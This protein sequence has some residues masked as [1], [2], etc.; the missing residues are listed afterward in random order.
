MLD[1]WSLVG[2]AGVPV[3]QRSLNVEIDGCDAHS[4]MG[5]EDAQVSSRRCLPGAPFCRAN[6]EPLRGSLIAGMSTGRD[7]P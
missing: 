3:C 2:P 7:L 6:Y 5:G 4:T 1:T